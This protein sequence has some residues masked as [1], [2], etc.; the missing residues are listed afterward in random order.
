MPLTATPIGDT[1]F[2]WVRISNDILGNVKPASP[3]PNPTTGGV[4][5][6]CE[7][8]F[9]ER[10]LPSIERNPWE[11]RYR[12]GPFGFM[13]FDVE[14]TFPGETVRFVNELAIDFDLDAWAR[15]MVEVPP[16]VDVT[17]E[18]ERYGNKG[19]AVIA[20]TMK[21]GRA[22]NVRVPIPA[23]EPF[24]PT[25]TAILEKLRRTA[26]APIPDL[27]GELPDHTCGAHLAMLIRRLDAHGHA[28][29]RKW[30]DKDTASRRNPSATGGQY[31]GSTL[32]IPGAFLIGA[33]VR[34]LTLA[35]THK[36]NAVHATLTM[37]G[38]HTL[39][40]DETGTSI[41]LHA[42]LP[43]TVIA[44]LRKRSVGDLVDVEWARPLTVRTV[45]SSDG[46][47]ITFR[48]FSETVPFTLG[49]P[50]PTTPEDV[51]ARLRRAFVDGVPR[52]NGSVPLW[53]EMDTALVP[54]LTG[55]DRLRLSIVLAELEL[56]N[57]VSLDDHGA[58][59]WTLR[60]SGPRLVADRQPAIPVEEIAALMPRSGDSG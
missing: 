60:N 55:M 36:S 6:V 31:H 35:T 15:K 21:K 52:L 4:V 38:E 48:A 5:L 2:S 49:D 45:P 20:R 14:Q 3:T 32:Q 34:R 17:F 53:S 54:I 41:D 40:D 44:A 10:L 59:G 56:F 58:P 12:M 57:Q 29:V 13:P 28:M 42:Q 24:A 43:E 11:V 50:V 7:D 27:L 51:E 1:G 46:G 9:L 18:R 22:T 26:P 23:S 47:H 39:T 33:K 30:I 8:A 19:V 25:V 37:Q 16:E